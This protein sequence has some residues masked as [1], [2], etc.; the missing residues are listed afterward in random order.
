MDKVNS[1]YDRFVEWSLERNWFRVSSTKLDNS[2][3]EDLY[4]TPTGQEVMIRIDNGEVTEVTTR[5]C[6]LEI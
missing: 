1:A 3:F 5:T 4:V 6:F 2:C